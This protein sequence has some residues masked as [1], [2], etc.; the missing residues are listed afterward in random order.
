MVSRL[1]GSPGKLTLE[2]DKKAY[3][4]GE[5]V[6]AK[7]AVSCNRDTEIEEGY[8]EL[9]CTGTYDR[10]TRRAT[11]RDTYSQ[12]GLAV[13]LFRA[14][15]V[16]APKST[17]PRGMPQA[18]TVT[19]DIPADAPTTYGKTRA[20]WRV[21]AVCDVRRGRDITREMQIVVRAQPG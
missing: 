20:K 3:K 11:A 5:R 21:K 14:K 16:F 13:D 18:Y 17:I 6:E 19:F 12:Q 8:V 10:G 9:T 2:L 7:V 1:F 4:P 15:S